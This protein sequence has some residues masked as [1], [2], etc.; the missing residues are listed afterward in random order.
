MP[1]K[2]KTVSTIRCYYV[3]GATRGLRLIGVGPSDLDLAKDLDASPEDTLRLEITATL[4]KG[5]TGTIQYRVLQLF[6]E[7]G[8]IETTKRWQAWAGKRLGVKP[9]SIKG[10][11]PPLVQRRKLV[12][13]RKGSKYR[14]GIYG[15][16]KKRGT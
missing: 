3:I 5:R 16:P 1:R 7:A 8:E 10:A 15:I 11:I 14:A 6:E 4:D 13:I 9:I 12:Q 2:P